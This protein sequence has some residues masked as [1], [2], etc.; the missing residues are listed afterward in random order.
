VEEGTSRKYVRPEIQ[1][2]KLLMERTGQNNSLDY[3]LKGRLGLEGLIGRGA[4]DTGK[5]GCSELGDAGNMDSPCP[6]TR[7]SINGNQFFNN[8]ICH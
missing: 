1:T 2:F 5:K 3:L 6:L 7:A 8:A 4:T